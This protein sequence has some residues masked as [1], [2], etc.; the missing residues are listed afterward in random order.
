MQLGIQS[1]YVSDCCLRVW[2]E[3]GWVPTMRNRA[4]WGTITACA[5]VG[6]YMMSDE[7]YH[8]GKGRQR[9][10]GRHFWGREVS[11]WRMGLQEATY[12]ARRLAAWFRGRCI[13]SQRSIGTQ[14]PEAEAEANPDYDL[15]D[16]E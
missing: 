12:G 4:F 6:L 9:V 15:C 14:A 11:A 1:L 16:V 10:P 3:G 5:L 13:S 7:P 2:V 8:C